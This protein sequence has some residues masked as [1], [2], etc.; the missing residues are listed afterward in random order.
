LGDPLG[1]AVTRPKPLEMRR[2]LKQSS[3]RHSRRLSTPEARRC[4]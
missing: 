2:A 4:S 3:I 1:M